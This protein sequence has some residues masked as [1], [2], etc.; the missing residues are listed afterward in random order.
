[1]RRPTSISRFAAPSRAARRYP[2]RPATNAV[3]NA[4]ST[5]INNPSA[6][7]A[8]VRYGWRPASLERRRPPLR[9]LQPASRVV[10]IRL[11]A[12]PSIPRPCASALRLSDTRDLHLDLAGGS[13]DRPRQ[14]AR[15]LGDVRPHRL[16]EPSIVPAATGLSDTHR[17]LRLAAGPFQIFAYPRRRAMTV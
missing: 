15:K 7:A 13:N 9:S 16:I 1:M 11:C 12:N 3:T 6:I 17:S 14:H 4:S 5:T 8:R 2:L 10:T